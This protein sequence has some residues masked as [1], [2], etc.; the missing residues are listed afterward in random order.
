[1][2]LSTVKWAK[3]DKTQSRE[4]LVLFI[5]VCSSL[6]TIVAHNTA[7]NRPDNFPSCPT[8]NHHCSDDVYLRERGYT[9]Y[10]HWQSTKI[11]QQKTSVTTTTIPEVG[12]YDN[13]HLSSV[14]TKYSSSNYFWFWRRW[15]EITRSPDT[16]HRYVYEYNYWT[17]HS[18][19]QRHWAMARSVASPAWVRRPAARRTHWTFD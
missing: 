14:H 12:R 9:K 4:L 15:N 18:S 7:Q 8:D 11:Q 2:N 19:R 17:T 5:C 10:T 1:M 6:C 3:W 13:A 16:R